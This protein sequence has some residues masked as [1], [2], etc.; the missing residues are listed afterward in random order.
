[1]SSIRAY[2]ENIIYYNEDN[3]YAVLEASAGSSMITLVGH[4]P[5]ISAG[6][7]IEAEGEYT[8]HPVYGEQF[9]V[10]SFQVTAPEGADAIERYLAGGAIKGIGPALAKRIVKKF[11]ADTFRI[12]EEEPERLAE[13]KGI[14]E[15][16]A[17]L[18]S[19][20][21]QIK[22]GMRDAVMYMQQFGIGS[23]LANRIYEKYGPALYAIL[24]SNPYRLAED[25]DGI[26]FRTADRIAI[27]MGIEADSEFRIRCGLLYVLTLAAADGH[28]WL[29]KDMLRSRTEE[30]L[31]LRVT[32]MDRFLM[33]LQ[34]DGRIVMVDK[35]AEPALWHPADPGDADIDCVTEISEPEQWP[36]SQP[37]GETQVYLSAYYYT[38]RN[39]AERLHA[40]AIR[41]ES[42]EAF[43]DQRIRKI[44][45]ETGIELDDMQREAVRASVNHGLLI[46]TGG[47]GTGKTTTINTLIR[48]YAEDHDEIMLAAPTGRAAKRMTEATGQEAKTIHRMLEYTGVPE[49]GNAPGNTSSYEGTRQGLDGEAVP[50]G[51]AGNA[52]GAGSTSGKGRFMRDEK[53]PLEAEVLIID[54][55]SMVDIFLMDALLKAVVPGTRVILVGDSNQ[56]P[57]VGAGNVLRDLISSGCFETVCLKHIFRQAAQSDIVLNAHRINNGEKVDLGKRSDDFLFIR[58]TRPESIISAVKTLITDKLPGYVDC[59]PLDIQVLCATRKGALGVEL[60]NRDLQAYLNPPSKDKAERKSGEMVLRTGDKVMQI[61]NDY[62]LEW[63]RYDDRGMPMEHG[64]GVFNGDIGRIGKID[65]LADTVTVIYDD[66]RYVKYDRKQIQNVELAYAVTV[67]KSQGSEYPAVVMPMYRGPH[68]LMNRNLLYTAVTRARKC[69]C[70]VGLPQVFE[71]MERNESESKRYTG[72]RDRIVERY[73]VSAE[74]PGM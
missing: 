7:S 46:L 17:M 48:F 29:P 22:R 27:K 69:V 55:M 57:S 59:D 11:K 40:L 41:G 10:S 54:E 34:I 73:S 21:A 37:E 32:D 62:D 24:N 15:H 31:D 20:Q 3:Y 4:F 30:L 74:M 51:G 56:L 67:H 16:M 58:S 2:I 5:Y 1:M 68:L 26:G 23:G 19:E 33:D 14:S 18:I 64:S 36:P 25:M 44:E 39:I 63:T 65:D 70:M 49:Q 52:G 8:S 13:I 43:V 66:N 50:Y 71:E 6:E 72:L 12:I 53:D 60:L 9:S 38:E 28:T 42:D 45:R 61:K 47:P 35:P